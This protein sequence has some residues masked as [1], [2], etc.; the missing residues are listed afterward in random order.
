MQ[1]LN[2]W[3]EIT[4][5]QF[6]QLKS[7]EAD[8]FHSLLSF[9]MDQLFIL[10]D[11]NIDDD[12]WNDIDTDKLQEIFEQMKWLNV[13]PT[14]NFSRKVLKYHFKELNSITLGEFIDLESLFNINYLLKLPNICAIL[15]RQHRLNE[16]NHTIIEPRKYNEKERADEFLDVKITE[17]FGIIQA[18]LSF[19]KKFVE[20]FENMFEEPDDF[21]DKEPQP[22]PETAEEIEAIR[23]EKA[24][25]KWNWERIIYKLMHTHNL[26]FEEVTELKL[27]FVFNQLAMQKDLKL[28]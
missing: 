6:I 14:L 1:L 18:Y 5:D 9:K 3:E 2:S 24:I 21:V 25:A 10:T 17:V 12:V 23:Q 28:D 27:I 22:E 8:D 20:G 13:Q 19:K 26:T 11:T 15:Y 4:L 7:V 16:W